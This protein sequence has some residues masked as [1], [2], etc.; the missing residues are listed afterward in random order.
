MTIH[1]NICRIWIAAAFLAAVGVVAAPGVDVDPTYSGQQGQAGQDVI[2]RFIQVTNTG[3]AADTLDLT[4]NSN[5]GWS[6][7][8]RDDSSQVM[9]VDSDGNGTWDTVNAGFDTDGDGLPDT[10][11]LAAGASV[12]FDLVVS[13]PV[14]TAN[15]TIDAAEFTATSSLDTNVNDTETVTT[16]VNND[17]TICNCGYGDGVMASNTGITIED[18]GDANHDNNMDD[19]ATV[20]ADLDNNTCDGASDGTNTFLPQPDLDGPVQS[21][22]RDL[23]HFAFTWDSTHV[24]AF[25]ARAAS[26][27]NVQRF[28][29]YADTNN[30][31]KMETGERVIVAQWQGS[32]RAVSLY[33][34]TYVQA[35]AGG[36]D[37]VDANGLADGYQLPGSAIGFPAVGKPDQSG[38]WGDTSGTQMEWEV[39]WSVLGIPAGSAFT[40][41]V[42]STNS[43][44]GAGSFPE[45]V[46][47]NMGGCGGGPASNQF[48]ALTF[49]DNE[50]VNTEPLSTECLPHILTNNGN[51][52]DSFTFSSVSSGDFTP[53]TIAIFVDADDSGTL[54][55]GDVNVT[56]TGVVD[57]AKDTSINLLICYTMGATDSGTATVV[58]T[59]TSVYDAN[60]SDSVT[61]TLISAPQPSFTVVKSVSVENDNL[62]DGGDYYIPGAEIIYS[63]TVSN[64]GMGSE[65][66]NTFVLSDVI[67]D[68][69]TMY[70]GDYAGAGEGPVTFNNTLNGSP[71]SGLTYDFDTLGSVTDDI[72]FK[73]STGT[74][75]TPDASSDGGYDDSVR[76]FEIRP[77]TAFAGWSGTGDYP[78]FTITFRAR[79]K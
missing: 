61:D 28:I 12:S 8:L 6:V 51:G 7:E 23:S 70:V 65:D 50:S 37:M 46:D 31:S 77:S 20:L 10:G 71:S 63:I 17:T 55:A 40:F 79:I 54:T 16:T 60:K 15:G 14:G 32:N 52:T 25:T 18:T 72:V 78:S 66:D 5:L 75:I 21:T 43:Q 57:L 74:S 56:N 22:G 3:D 38:D 53:D 1:A 29:Y 4:V 47:D 68:N 30:N 11:S 45:Q 2:H 44:P 48:A 73:N 33:Y 67:P 76:S 9:A 34:G 19:W 42:S 41:H 49:V 59:A 35:N 27:T 64:T 24:Q 13:I 39:P 58:T 69:L 26:S 36:D 62:D